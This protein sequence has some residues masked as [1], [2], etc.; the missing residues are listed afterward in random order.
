MVVA[1]RPRFRLV[2]II[3]GMLAR[4]PERTE[5][6]S[7]SAASPNFFPVACSMCF[8]AVSTCSVSPSG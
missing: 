7:G 6:S 2:A 4:A 5:S 3:P 8:T 1:L